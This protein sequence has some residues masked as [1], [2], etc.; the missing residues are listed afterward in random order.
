VNRAPA[1][2]VARNLLRTPGRPFLEYLWIEEDTVNGNQVRTVPTAQLPLA[3]TVALHGDPQDR[4]DN[5]GRIDRIR[6]VRVSVTATNGLSGAREVRR[7]A[8]RVVQLANAGISALQACGEPPVAGLALGANPVAL[9]GGS[10]RVDL[11]WNAAPDETGGERDVLRYVIWRRVS[12]TT[13][14]GDPYLSVS[15]GIN[16]YQYRDEQV[17]GGV[18]YDYAIASQDCTPSLSPLATTVNIQVPLPLP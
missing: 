15:S 6:G 7:S 16:A 13:N 10:V 4:P 17:V 1:A 9:P 2:V 8:T 18:R 12:G 11:S 3:H 5:Q 14:W